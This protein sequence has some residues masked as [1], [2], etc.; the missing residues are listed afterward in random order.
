MLAHQLR[1]LGL[2]VTVVPWTVAAVPDADLVHQVEGG[3]GHGPIDGGG[4]VVGLDLEQYLVLDHP[5]E[6]ALRC[7][8]HVDTDRVG[9]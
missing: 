4:R 1:A 6:R 9:Q 3:G 5:D 2:A 8:R 7:D